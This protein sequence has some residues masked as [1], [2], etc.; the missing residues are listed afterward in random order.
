[1]SAEPGPALAAGNTA[2]RPKRPTIDPLAEVLRRAA[3]MAEDRAVR[4]WLCRLQQGETA[5]PGRSPKG[6]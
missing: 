3:A 6:K 4:D 5:G 2:R 1:M